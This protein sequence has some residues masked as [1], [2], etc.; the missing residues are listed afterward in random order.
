MVSDLEGVVS[1]L[2]GVVF[3]LEGV[4]SDLEGVVSCSGGGPEVTLTAFPG[5]RNTV[6]TVAEVL[7]LLLIAFSSM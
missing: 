2:E 3:E 6:P 4:V 5:G 7:S 1:E